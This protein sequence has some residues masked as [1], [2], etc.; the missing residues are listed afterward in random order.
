M[1]K[2]I[3]ICRFCGKECK[4]SNSLKQ[5]ECR[6]YENPNRIIENKLEIEAYEKSPK[7]CPICCNVIPYKKRHQKTCSPECGN[8]LRTNNSINTKNLNEYNNEYICKYCGRICK[9]GNSL[10]NHERLCK[11][12]PDRQIIVSNVS[13]FIKWNEY[14]KGKNLQ[15]PSN[16]YI[17]SRELGIEYKI[18]DETRKKLSKASS[19]RVY[20]KEYKDRLSKKMKEVAQNNP[21]YSYSKN[22]YFK[23]EII[24]GFR[25]DSSW[26]SIFANYLNQND[27]KW[28]KNTKPFKYIF[29]N[30]EHS[31]YPDFY[32]KDFDLYIEV[33]GNETEKDKAKYKVVDNLLVLRSKEIDEIKKNEF[34]IFSFIKNTKK[35]DI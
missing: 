21:K 8:V 6:C 12:N 17:K 14:R 27:I 15:K 19:G 28:I 3:F 2:S 34:N 29:E 30:E 5:H 9:N 1:N 18:S 32:L 35:L 31:Y 23:K 33:K 26:E 11:E 25:M 22:K 7:I 13:N 10:I 24:N 16:Q 4:N 20:S